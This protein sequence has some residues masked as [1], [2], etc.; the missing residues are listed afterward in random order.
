MGS[1]LSDTWVSIV[2]FSNTGVITFPMTE[3][4]ETG[5]VRKFNLNSCEYF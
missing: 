3:M 5:K 4:N 1:L 2:T